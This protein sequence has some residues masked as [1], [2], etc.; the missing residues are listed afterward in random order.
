MCCIVRVTYRLQPKF[1][2]PFVYRV[3]VLCFSYRKAALKFNSLLPTEVKKNNDE[4]Q[5]YLTSQQNEFD[6]DYEF[7][8]QNGKLVELGRGTFGV[9]YKV[10]SKH[11]AGPPLAIKFPLQIGSFPRAKEAIK[12]CMEE[13]RIWSKLSNPYIL[14]LR[15]YYVLQIPGKTFPAL[16]PVTAAV[17]DGD[18]MTRIFDFEEKNPNGVLGLPRDEAWLA[19]KQLLLARESISVELHRNMHCSSSSGSTKLTIV[20]SIKLNSPIYA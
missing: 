12:D 16:C 4:F 9:V 10:Q 13:V 6:K 3:D 20:A 1:P 2:L 8:T 11:V 15:G 5:E 14:K 19:S 7:V 17:P 18:L